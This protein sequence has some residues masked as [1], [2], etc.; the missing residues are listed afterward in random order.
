MNMD[1]ASDVE[2]VKLFKSGDAAA[3]DA[4]VLRFQD[5]V[6][7]LAC[8]WLYDEQFAAD[9]AQEVFVRGFKGLRAFRFRSAP[10][11]WLYRTTRNVCS[12]F[13][14]VRRSEALLDEPPDSS[15]IPETQITQLDSARRVRQ[16][17][18]NL[19][20]RQREVVMLR[21]FEDLSVKE[22]ALAMGCR[23]GT[24]KALLHKATG[25]L[26]QSTSEVGLS[27]E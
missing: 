20:D 22:T 12:E 7:R 25:N 13:N 2:L 17:V 11:T 27:D 26:K 23:E 14:R 4:I 15:S 18:A 1:D 6:Y 24:V 19:P 8:I 3:F 5:R 21:I 9:A 10:F 16:L